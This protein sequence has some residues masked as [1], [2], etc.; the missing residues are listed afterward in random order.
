MRSRDIE[1]L[2][3]IIEYATAF[4]KW[5]LIAILVGLF[6]GL[7]GSLFRMGI[8][9]VTSIR[10]GHSFLIYFLPLAGLAIPALYKLFRVEKDL[11]TNL[12]IDTVRTDG[13]VPANMSVL[14]IAGTLITHLFG[15]SI[16]REGA[17]LQLGGSLGSMVGRFFRLDEKDK[18]Y[19]VMCGMSGLFAALFG[20][21]MTAAF[22]AL[23]VISVGIMYYSALFPCV[24][25]AI[26]SFLVSLAFKLP[27]ENFG[28][29]A[30][31][32]ISIS[33]LLKVAV[34]GILCALLSMLFCVLLQK[35]GKILGWII[36]NDYIRIA[37][38]GGVIVLLTMLVG[39][40]DYN[41]AGLEVIERAIGGEVNW[42]AFLLKM[43]FTAITIGAGFKGGEIVPSF[44]VGATFG[45]LMGMLLGVDP[46]F[47]AALGLVAL[48][49]GVT[50]CPLAS[51][52]LS[53]ELFGASG[54]VYFC[55]ACA[56][57]YMLSGYY[58]L[59]SSQKI[60]YSKIKGEFI[61]RNANK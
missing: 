2:L 36:R 31:P 46:G 18:H 39:T 37:V 9:A 4:I 24:V 28:K 19:L 41:G 48:F 10:Q 12:V 7:V 38:F 45:C 44:F 40:N 14:I 51:T 21:P 60:M 29:V 57:S 35:T 23:E 47:A 6:C 53:V 32:D 42:E 3:T 22:F 30:F 54:I 34:I 20:T 59:Y 49:C 8:D 13:E 15:G 17:A 58:S 26:V 33:I 1:R 25:S 16:G 5:L 27:A 43:L 56:I 61:N 52:I 11:G 50:N 55:I